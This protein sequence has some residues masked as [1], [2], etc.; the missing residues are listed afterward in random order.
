LSFEAAA[1]GAVVLGIALVAA[2]I[3][4]SI[5][6]HGDL[7]LC[8][9]L[10]AAALL[11]T[12]K[13]EWGRAALAELEHVPQR[14][15]LVFALGAPRWSVTARPPVLM[16]GLCAIALVL[17]ASATVVGFNGRLDLRFG[18]SVGLALALLAL[19]SLMATVVGAEQRLVMALAV[20]ES[21]LLIGLSFPWPGLLDPNFPP[22]WA[23]PSVSPPTPFG[24]PFRA[25]VLLQGLVVFSPLAAVAG[26]RGWRSAVAVVGWSSLLCGASLFSAAVISLYVFRDGPFVFDSGSLD[27]AVAAMLGASGAA[28]WV[29]LPGAMAGVLASRCAARVRGSVS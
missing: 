18:L 13:A 6:A 25:L 9:M 11:P 8:L 28:L 19:Y 21:A 10:L 12:E 29:T 15:R 17:L 2:G 16:L 22:P 1:L 20:L 3:R 27:R 23:E 14:R 5:V 24:I 7:P 4:I 26:W